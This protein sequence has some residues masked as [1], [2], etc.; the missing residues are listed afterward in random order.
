MCADVVSVRWSPCGLYFGVL[1]DGC[2]LI[3]SIKEEREVYID[4]E[5]REKQLND[6]ISQPS[7]RC[8]HKQHQIKYILIN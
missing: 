8:T 4:K 1:F 7:S 6:Y 5:E 3:K 2:L